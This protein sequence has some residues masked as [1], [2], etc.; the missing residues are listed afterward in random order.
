MDRNTTR[1]TTY[2]SLSEH[3]AEEGVDWIVWPETAVPG[4]LENDSILRG[5]LAD[6]ATRHDF[7]R[8]VLNQEDL[9]ERNGQRRKLFTKVTHVSAPLTP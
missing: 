1:H 7:L 5:R 2:L 4:V 3:A 8:H 6:L 9:A